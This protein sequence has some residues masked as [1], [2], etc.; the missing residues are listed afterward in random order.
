MAAAPE[1]CYKKQIIST[2]TDN[3]DKVWITQLDI[4]CEIPFHNRGLTGKD[5]IVS[6]SNTGLDLKSCYFSESSAPDKDVLVHSLV[7][8]TGRLSNMCRTTFLT[9]LTL[10]IY[11]NWIMIC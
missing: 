4:V 9:A 1:I 8:Q 6:A 5:Q 7:F 10:T 2:Y 3:T 11:L